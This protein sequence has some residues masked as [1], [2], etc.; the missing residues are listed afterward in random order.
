MTSKSNGRI[1]TSLGKHEPREKRADGDRWRMG[2]VAYRAKWGRLRLLDRE[3]DEIPG[4]DS[5]LE[6]EDK[7]FARLPELT[8]V[9]I[10]P[11]PGDR[12]VP[13][14]S[15][16]GDQPLDAVAWKSAVVDCR[17]GPTRCRGGWKACRRPR[18]PRSSAWSC[19]E[20]A[21]EPGLT[22]PVPR[23]TGAHGT[24]VTETPRQRRRVRRC[25]GR[26]ARSRR[27]VTPSFVFRLRCRGDA[28]RR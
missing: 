8:E 26:A 23:W 21:P 1:V 14:V 13:V 7:L 4:I 24:R 12:P 11:G 15:T 20:A 6:I 22:C 2:D 9:V 5:T 28:A 18:P 27:P 3:V 17:R 19:C 10:V 16:R 25:A